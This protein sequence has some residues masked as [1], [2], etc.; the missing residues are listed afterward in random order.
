MWKKK[1][2]ST[3]HCEVLVLVRFNL[4]VQGDERRRK[5]SQTD[6]GH[7]NEM[8]DRPDSRLDWQLCLEDNDE[9]WLHI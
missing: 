4:A 7:I 9:L 1:K 8:L 5:R 6:E 2:T 3:H